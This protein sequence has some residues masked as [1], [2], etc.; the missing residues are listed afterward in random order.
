MTAGYFILIISSATL[1]EPSGKIK[2]GRIQKMKDREIR[3][4]A[5][6]VSLLAAFAVWTVLI[7]TIDVQAAGVNGTDIGFATV[8]RGFHEWTGVH[9][10]LYVITD[11]LGLIPAGAGII[12]AIVGLVQWIRRRSIA[13]VDGDILMLGVYF[14][15]VITGYLAFEMIPVNYRP[16]LINGVMEASYPSSTTLL[17]LSVMLAAAFQA[18]RRLKRIRVQRIIPVMAMIFSVFMVTGRLISGVHWLTDIT[19]SVF[20]SMGLYVIY[21]A[22]VLRYDK[23]KK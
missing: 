14:I 4:L 13:K 8:N 23:I 21:K 1:R 5:A 3:L 17:V 10:E 12:F 19:G 7:L 11:W 6:G 9:M 15:I 18:K 16:V 20:L 22:L 2:V